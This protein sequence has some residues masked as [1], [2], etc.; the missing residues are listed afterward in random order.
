MASR[1]IKN[2]KIHFISLA[3]RCR[4]TKFKNL[5]LG[6]IFQKPK[7]CGVSVYDNIYISGSNCDLIINNP[8]VI[9]LKNKFWTDKLAMSYGDK[10]TGE[11]VTSKDLY[12]LLAININ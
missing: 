7:K 5:R 12:V 8:Y 6:K 2:Q 9:G 1:S 3:I 11:F 10:V 4:L